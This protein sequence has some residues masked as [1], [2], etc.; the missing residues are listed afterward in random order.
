MRRRSIIEQRHVRSR[1]DHL[2]GSGDFD[3]FEPASPD[4]HRRHFRLRDSL[5]VA[6]YGFGSSFAAA[7]GFNHGCRTRNHVSGCKDACNGGL[8][9]DV[10]DHDGIALGPFEF[11]RRI[12]GIPVHRLTNGRNDGIHF[13]EMFAA[14]TA[15]R[16][17]SALFVRL[18][19]FRSETVQ[20]PSLCH[21][22]P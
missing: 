1:Q 18:S 6:V 9:G 17:P 15:N 19:Q 16:T 3:A 12:G 14:F 10:V 13:Q 5:Q 21:R 2:G 8:H 11:R 7:D 22:S 4:R 20:R